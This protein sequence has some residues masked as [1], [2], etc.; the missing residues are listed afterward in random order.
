[1]RKVTSV[2]VVY[3]FRVTVSSAMDD[4]AVTS[5]VISFPGGSP[6]C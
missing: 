4:Y 2:K 6:T 5:A 3:K 1:M